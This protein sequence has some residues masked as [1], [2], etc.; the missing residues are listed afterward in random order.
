M[1]KERN[2]VFT[3]LNVHSPVSLQPE[4]V[5]LCKFLNFVLEFKG[6]QVFFLKKTNAL[7]KNYCFF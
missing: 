1:N 7:K 3:N 2:L 6:Y 5:N 4:D